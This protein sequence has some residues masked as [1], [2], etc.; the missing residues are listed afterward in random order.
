MLVPLAGGERPEQHHS[1]VVDKDV[2]APE[3]AAHAFGGG[4]DRVSIGD[5]GLDRDRA[6]TQ[7][8]SQ[9]VDAVAAAGQQRKAVPGNGERACGRLA[10]PGRRAG[11]DRNAAGIL[12]CGHGVVPGRWQAGR[13]SC[14]V[15]SL[16]HA[17]LDSMA[18]S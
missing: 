11:D 4:H 17:P 7:L 16:N 14:R 2:R 9:R 12:V 5:V 3:L 10:D 6:A 13:R 8:G 15:A 18:I 1:G